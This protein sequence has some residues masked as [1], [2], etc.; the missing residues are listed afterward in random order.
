MTDTVLYFRTKRC[1][2]DV[3]SVGNKDRVVAKTIGAGR[4]KGDFSFN[5]TFENPGLFFRFDKC[6]GRL[7]S[8]GTFFFRN[9]CE[10]L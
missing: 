6:K 4:A 1:N 7:K 3:I 5:R 2:G 8:G 10:L 9:L